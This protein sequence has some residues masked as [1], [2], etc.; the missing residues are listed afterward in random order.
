[1]HSAN[2]HVHPIGHFTSWFMIKISTPRPSQRHGMIQ[3]M[4]ALTYM[5]YTY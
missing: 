3:I 4:N 5:Y 2:A 1:M